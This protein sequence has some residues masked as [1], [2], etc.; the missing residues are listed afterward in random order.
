M[1]ICLPR[2]NN[3]ENPSL[4]SLLLGALEEPTKY[5]HT[6]RKMTFFRAGG[7]VLQFPEQRE[8]E[9]FSLL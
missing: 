4:L 6:L 1:Y 2:E 7:R 9:F 3:Q 8:R 5:T